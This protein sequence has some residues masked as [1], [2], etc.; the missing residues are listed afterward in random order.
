EPPYRSRDTDQIWIRHLYDQ[1]DVPV[2][3]VGAIESE[4]IV[5]AENVLYIVHVGNTV[6]NLKPRDRPCHARR[7]RL[8][9]RWPRRRTA[10]HR[11]L[12]Q[13]WRHGFRLF[14]RNFGSRGWQFDVERQIAVHPEQRAVLQGRGALYGGS[15]RRPG[16]PPLLQALPHIHDPM[17]LF[18][19][20]RG[21]C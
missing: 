21:L 3:M 17:S 18:H 5:I 19:L 11:P 9:F 14:L 1:I 6:P 8:P 12:E 15:V 20:T 13:G 4:Q 16:P 10:F 7:H 2:W